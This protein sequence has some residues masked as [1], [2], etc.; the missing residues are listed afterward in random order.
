MY[1]ASKLCHIA[2]CYRHDYEKDGYQ[3]Y[4]RDRENGI[5]IWYYRHAN[6]NRIAIRLDLN[7]MC[8]TIFKNAQV[9]NKIE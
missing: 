3:P 7:K 2:A 4:S 1:T 6:G 9:I 8:I 5:A